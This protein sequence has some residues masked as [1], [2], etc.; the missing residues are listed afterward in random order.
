M[1][2]TI[3]ASASAAAA[4]MLVVG[5]GLAVANASPHGSASPATSG[6]EHLYLM[7]TS[8]AS[9]KASLIVSGV[10]TANGVDIEGN[11]PTDT[12]RLPGGT[13][14]IHHPAGGPPGK[15]KVNALTC[16]VTIS[17]SARFTINGG[18]GKFAGL[19]GAGKAL[20]TIVGILGRSHG[21]CSESALPAAWHETIT[22]TA[23]VHL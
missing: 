7:T 22:A 13:F 17:G 10:F 2:K 5:G 1:R 3:A 19:T 8:A 6:T 11:G 16:F 9:N 12:V 20:V 15:P 4:S 21:K 18:T 14:K 23:H